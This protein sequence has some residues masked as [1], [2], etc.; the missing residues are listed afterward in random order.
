MS[1]I[2]YFDCFSGA[3]G[4][5]LLGALLDSGYPLEDLRA[6]LGALGVTGY[7]LVLR[8][9]QQHGITGS[10]FDVVDLAGE[11]P[12]RNLS[13]IRE[14]LGKAD[15]PDGI[16]DQSLRV[17]T[18][19]GEAEA[20]IHGVSIDEVHFHEVGAIDALVDIV[21]TCLVLHNLGVDAVYSSPLPLGSGTVRT[22]H[23]LLPVPAPATLAL[24]AEV[25]APTVPLDARGEMVTPT[26]AALLTT[27]AT[28]ERPAMRVTR[29][30]YGFGTKTFPWANMVRVWIGES[31]EGALPETRH[32]LLAARGAD[33]AEQAHERADVAH[34]H[35]HEHAG[36][37]HEHSHHHEA[38]HG[39]P[40]PHENGHRHDDADA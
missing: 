33:A 13:L 22:E 7:D 24:L 17:F 30:G 40:H 8:R 15:L 6:G 25:G 18:R 12:V 27:L 37:A 9:V 23:G 19:L 39:H 28:F 14:I 21:G 26:G 4:D 2:A 1:T 31:M 32:A 36:E 20:R 11:R 35:R 10:K 29:V 38:G 3:A 5:M 16:A 34:P